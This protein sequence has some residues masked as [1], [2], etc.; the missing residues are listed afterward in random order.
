MDGA[1]GRLLVHS[2]VGPLVKLVATAVVAVVGFLAWA[3]GGGV[4]ADLLA[5]AGWDG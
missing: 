3:F 5:L 1:G 2:D 4:V